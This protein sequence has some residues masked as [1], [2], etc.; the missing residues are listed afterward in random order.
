MLTNTRV[1]NSCSTA[2]RDSGR[3]LDDAFGE[4]DPRADV[5]GIAGQYF[6]LGGSGS[7]TAMKLVANTLLEVGMQAIAESIALGQKEGLD[8]FETSSR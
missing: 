5:R 3:N 7:R 2:D 4:N 6:H 8:S 1:D